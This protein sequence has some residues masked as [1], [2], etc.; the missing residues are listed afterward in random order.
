MV[1]GRIEVFRYARRCV[2][3]TQLRAIFLRTH[4]PPVASFSIVRQIDS[5]QHG[6]TAVEPPHQ[7]RFIETHTRVYWY[8][9]IYISHCVFYTRW[10]AAVCRCE[11]SFI[12]ILSCGSIIPFN[13][14]ALPTQLW[15]SRCSILLQME[16]YCV[17]MNHG[18][19]LI[20]FILLDGSQKNLSV[21]NHVIKRNYFTKVY[22]LVE[23]L[24]L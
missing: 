6:L 15:K 24:I 1:I 23:N 4:S 19:L 16:C 9:S 21:Q 14:P 13:I 5:S 8:Y 7:H 22:N 20:F 10:I 11:A 18:L 17:R 3:L 2:N 12:H